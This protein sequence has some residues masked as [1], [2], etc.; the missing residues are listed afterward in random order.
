MREG[1]GRNRESAPNVWS[2]HQTS[3]VST[4]HLVT[5]DYCTMFCAGLV[6]QMVSIHLKKTNWVI[7]KYVLF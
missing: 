1:N 6:S 7:S 5:E 2:Q 3:G 4:V